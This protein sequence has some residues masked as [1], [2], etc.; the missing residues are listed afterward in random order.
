M[1][2]STDLLLFIVLTEPKCIESFGT[3]LCA[4]ELSHCIENITETFISTRA[5]GIN[6]HSLIQ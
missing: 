1:Y 3:L 6:R 5:V 4:R 2:W